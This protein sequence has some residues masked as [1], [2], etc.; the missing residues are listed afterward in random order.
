MNMRKTIIAAALLLFVGSS[1]P[2]IAQSGFDPTPPADPQVPIFKYQLSVVAQRS[3][4]CYVSGSGKYAEGTQVTINTSARNGTNYT[5][6]HWLKDGEYYTGQQQFTYITTNQAVTFMAVWDF[7]PNVPDDPTSPYFAPKHILALES[8]P[9]DCCAFNR[10]SGL[11][12]EEES[13]VTLSV[14]PNQY[15]EFTGWY[16]GTTL[17]N[18]NA[19]FSYQMPSEDVTLTAHFEYHPFDPTTPGDPN[20]EQSSVD[21]GIVGDVNGDS[22]VD[23]VDAVQ[24]INAY[25]SNTTDVLNMR[26]ADMNSDDAIDIVDA[27]IIINQYLGKE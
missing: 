11:K 1:L 24:I 3:D 27:V 14:T 13:M 20:S 6:S 12:T 21:N 23:I 10:A 9:A 8:D 16:N 18:S 25:L 7:T 2:A 22:V 17:V 4:A 19:T 5:F 15:Y 26:L